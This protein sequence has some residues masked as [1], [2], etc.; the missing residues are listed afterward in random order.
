MSIVVRGA[1]YE[2]EA[3]VTAMTAEGFDAEDHD[4]FRRACDADPW[5]CPELHRIC[6]VDGRIVSA[7]RVVRRWIRY[8]HS[9]LELGGI[10]DVT[11]L[12]E[13]RGKGYGT[14]VVQD[15]IEWMREHRFD[16]SL[17]FTG[18]R[19]FY[20]RLGYEC[21]ESRCDVFQLDDAAPPS[22]G[23]KVGEFDAARHL[24]GLMRL[25]EVAGRGRVGVMIRTPTYW[26]RRLARRTDSHGL[27]ISAHNGRITA[28][29]LC[30]YGE[31][32]QLLECGHEDERFGDLCGVLARVVA[33]AQ[34]RGATALHAWT[35]GQAHVR[36]LLRSWLGESEVKPE[37]PMALVLD[38]PRVLS[39]IQDELQRRLVAIRGPV[40]CGAFSL[41][42]DGHVVA[43]AVEDEAVAI[44]PGQRREQHVSLEQKDLLALLFSGGAEEALGERLQTLTDPSRTLLAVLFPP[45]EFAFSRVDGF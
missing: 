44:H 12:R 28:Y 38:L 26:E 25:H 16:F 31:T 37:Q 11:T 6:E 32:A 3:E 20:R 18:I 2:D 43:L 13:H 14:M 35:A 17:L 39:R 15:A 4:W 5:H 30:E 29:A 8:G 36:A 33:S 21:L 9:V 7:A 40:P 24:S 34:R 10:G 41:E 1:R 45:Q 19:D 42:V 23:A 27:L 22:P